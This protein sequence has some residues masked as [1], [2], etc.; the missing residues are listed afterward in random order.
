MNN[1]KKKFFSS[2]I[3]LSAFMAALPATAAIP[4]DVAGTRFEEPVQILSA[5]KIMNGDEN[6]QFRLEDTI[7]RSEVTKMIVHAL[8]LDSAA[9]SAYGTAKYDDVAADHWANGYI[10]V[11]TSQGLI[12]GD[13]DGNFRPN[14][15]ITYNEAMAIVVRATGYNIAAEEK[16]GYPT[17][18]MTVGTS[19]GFTKNVQCAP[20]EKISRGNVAYLTTNALETKLM[21]QKGFGSNISYEVTDKTLLKDVLKVE[22]LDGQITAV[23]NTSLTNGDGLNKNQIKIADKIYNTAYNMNNLLGYNVTCYIQSYQSKDDEV[24]L[25]L[26]IA[27]KNKSLRID[28][29]SFSRLTTKSSNPA[30]EY[31]TG[32]NNSKTSTAEIKSNATM[33]YNGKYTEFNKDLLDLTDKA[34]YISLLDAD[35]DGRYELV[36]VTNYENMVVESVSSSGRI[37]D[38][39]NAPSIKLDENVDF[40]IV[41]GSEDIEVSELQ[42]WDVLSIAKS[43]DNSL[44][45]VIVTRN[46]VEGE[47]TATENENDVYIGDK[48]YKVAANYTASLSIGLN[49]KF[50]LDAEGKIAAVDTSSKLSSGYAYLATAYTNTNSDGL[51]YFKLFTKE[52][53]TITVEGNSRVKFNGKSGI[54]PENVV[55][56]LTEDGKTVKQLVT[57]ATNSDGKLVTLDTAADKSETGAIDTENFTKNL[58]LENT[59]YSA[60]L[61]K[62]G[63]VRIDNNTIIFNITDNSDDYTIEK[64]EMFEDGQKYNAVVYDMNE[65]HTAKVVVLTGSAYTANAEAP[66]AVVKK[67]SVSTNSDGEQTNVLQALVDGKEISIFAED[68]NVL[69]KNGSEKLSTGDLIQY[70]TNSKGEIASIRLLLD[71]NKKNE[72]ATAEPAKD[73]KTVY[74]K[75]TKKF[76]NTINVTVN[77]GSVVNYAIPE[78][79]IVYEVDTTVSK[80][81][82]NK[83]SVS[84]I[85][86]YD[87]DEN[88]RIFIKIYKDVITELVIV[89]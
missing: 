40:R 52:G 36:F 49:G 81:N 28:S 9:E 27:S 82:V 19:Y 67:I 17:G 57:Y 83:A 8:G 35:K 4:A 85:Q 61:S 47:I 64:K 54:K 58:V 1:F 30:I 45:T 33:I 60:T 39:Y 86:S 84:D 50:Y 31:F 2:A 74:G 11:A 41:L 87:E 73:L 55:S 71:V 88:N 37:T 24:I 10:S 79:V 69:V 65:D 77:G 63:N 20:N 32:E 80:N 75:V 68:E 26:P 7:I 72:E 78:D 21:E 22:K 56:Q 76:S 3:A 62:L 5:L 13:G 66:L 43:L 53:K 70:K 16:G 46:A 14:D 48:L 18:Y 34:G 6:G 25:A 59:E 51:S 42:E 12:E 44:Y 29:E 89:K 23:E 15:T 38:K